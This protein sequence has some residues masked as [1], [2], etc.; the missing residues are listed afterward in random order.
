MRRIR[1]I[2][3]LTM[4]GG[5]LVKTVRFGFDQARYIGDPLNTMRLFNDK[6]VDELALLDIGATRRGEPPDLSR[7]AEMAGE[8]FMPLAYGGGIT[9]LDQI[10]AI[11][12]V[13]VEKVILNTALFEQPELVTRA[14][15]IFGSQS[16]VASIDVKRGLLGKA[17]VRTRCGRRRTG[18]TPLA[19][20]RQAVERG[21]GEI[22]LNSIDR[23]GTFQG[24]DLDLIRAV[25]A[26]VPVPVVA[27]GGASGVEDFLP[28]VREAAAS[29]VAA[30]SLFI[31][32]GR[33]RAVLVNYP[34]Q[35]LLRAQLFE[36]L[37]TA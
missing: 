12:Q 22:I 37:Q 27:L 7:I 29:A 25:A 9:R 23:D 18:L 8:C 35:D 5:G 31:Y 10:K 19:A 14:A 4:R 6:E 20:A 26:E 1:V 13:G 16:I 15:E 3:V 34:R 30:G 17:T 36:P 24:Y 11:F 32:Q 28:A 33:H 21:A 2:P